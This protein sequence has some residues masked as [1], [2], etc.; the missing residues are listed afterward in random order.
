MNT[1]PSQPAV[2]Q[3]AP[4]A[5]A[6][7]AERVKELTCLYEV[8]A[9]FAKRGGSVQGGEGSLRESLARVVAVLPA[10]CRFPERAVATLRLDGIEVASRAHGLDASSPRAPL[11]APLRI[12]GVERGEVAIAYSDGPEADGRSGDAGDAGEREGE[13]GF[14]A[15][16]QALLNTVAHQIGV[17]VASVEAEERRADIE[18]TLRHADR[19]ATIGQLAA[20]VAHELNEPLGN[21][22]GFAQLSLKAAEVPDQVRTDL[23][24]IAEAA[25]HG[26]E[27]IRKLLVFARQTPASK[28]ST[29][30]NGVVEE[31][32]FLLEAG[33]ENPGIRFVRE[34][35][36]DL[37]EIEADPVQVRQVVTNLVINAMQAIRE[38]GT[39][40]VRTFADGTQG[41]G[42]TGV[43]L[44]V[45]DTGAGMTPEVLRRIFDPFFTTKDVGQGTGLG[46]AVVQGIVVGHGGSIEVDSEPSRGSVFRVRIPVCAAAPRE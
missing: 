32:M 35:G 46:L 11:R 23:R 16:E 29:A 3:H 6:E 7:L 31:A 39:I 15:E 8:A 40:T 18:A 33:C 27:I 22:L 45:E 5:L 14:L 37:P 42:E 20:G 44:A 30:L 21:V 13:G 24:R 41:A 1:S 17:F 19:L 10:A 12:G 26:R 4:A 9:V 36:A 25:L 38:A 43:V 28:R 34:L 2:S